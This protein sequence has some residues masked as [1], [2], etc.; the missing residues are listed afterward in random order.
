MLGSRKHG[1]FPFSHAA[2]AT[3]HA[4]AQIVYDGKPTTDEGAI[5]AQAGAKGHRPC[6]RLEGKRKRALR[7]T[8][9]R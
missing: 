3:A 4:T 6:E 1:E 8:N 9:Q 2:H 7:D 5:A